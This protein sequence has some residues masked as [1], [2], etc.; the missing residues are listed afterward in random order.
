MAHGSKQWVLAADMPGGRVKRSRHRTNV[1]KLGRLAIGATVRKRDGWA[2]CRA[3]RAEARDHS[4]PPW[5]QCRQC[6]DD[7]A[8]RRRA[9]WGRWNWLRHA[10]ARFRRILEREYRARVRHLMA[11]RRYEE[12]PVRG[13]RNA[14]WQYW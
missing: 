4:L 1:D 3:C 5:Q 6:C 13:P 8:A 10:P 12:V 9:G 14:A 7:E 11:T 2:E